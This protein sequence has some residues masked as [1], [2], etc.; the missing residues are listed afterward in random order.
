MYYTVNTEAVMDVNMIPAVGPL[1]VDRPDGKKEN[2]KKFFNFTGTIQQVR[3]EGGKT[4][5]VMTADEPA[6]RLEGI[7]GE[8]AQVTN[9]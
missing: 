1:K 2:K 4:V 9:S 8:R 5:V 6:A 3:T 7:T